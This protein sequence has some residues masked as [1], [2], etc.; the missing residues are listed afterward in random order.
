MST[1]SARTNQKDTMRVSKLHTGPSK[2]EIYYGFLNSLKERA[3]PKDIYEKLKAV[4]F[5]KSIYKKLAAYAANDLNSMENLGLDPKK[6]LLLMGPVGCGK[7]ES[8]IFLGKVMRP[9]FKHERIHNIVTA[10][11]LNGDAGSVPRIKGPKRPNSHIYADMYIDDLG[12]ERTGSFFG[13]KAELGTDLILTRYQ[14][15]KEDNTKTHFTTNLF[16]E[17]LTASYQPICTSRLR[18]MCNT[19]YY[20]E[21]A[22]DLRF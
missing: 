8:M 17:D 16:P 12:T 20:S 13:A 6:G 10:Y 4:D 15:F 11:N 18:E 21:E 2:E 14:F 9:G 22:P 5:N 3:W 7:S 1:G 19:I